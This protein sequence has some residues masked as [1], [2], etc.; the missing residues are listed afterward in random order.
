MLTTIGAGATTIE[1]ADG[2]YTYDALYRL[3]LAKGREHAAG[4]VDG[5]DREIHAAVEADGRRRARAGD[6]RETADL[7]RLRL[8][9]GRRREGK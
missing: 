5:I 9:D 6:R 1:S 3:T 2:D 4:A 7:D 8:C